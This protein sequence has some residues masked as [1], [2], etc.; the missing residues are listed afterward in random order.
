M[1]EITV[2]LHGGVAVVTLDAPERR[3]A[4]TGKTAE[5]IVAEFEALG[6]NEQVGAVVI[7]GSPPAFCAGAS[8]ELLT[9]AGEPNGEDARQELD[10]IYGLFLAI[11]ASPV[12]TVSA[13]NGAA[14]GAGLNLALATDVCIVAR[15]AK[16]ISGFLRIDLHPGGGHHLLVRR[17]AGF[18]AANAMALF[19]D[20]IDGERAVEL[21]LAWRAVDP[22]DVLDTAVELASKAGAKPELAR[23]MARSVRR[24]SE[25]YGWSAQV[26][27]ERG[28]Q[29]TTLLRRGG[30]DHVG[31][32]PRNV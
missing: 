11:G 14:V 28:A 15:D 8:R 22:G 3:N 24:S 31:R 30:M 21:G 27:V 23:L 1:S 29:L 25:H 12:P 2:S 19:D 5:A 10:A 18:G 26:E 20:A 13:V 17:R 6:R 32:P 16:L 7:T 4:L 9:R